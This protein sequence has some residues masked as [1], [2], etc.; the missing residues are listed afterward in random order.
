MKWLPVRLSPRHS[1]LLLALVASVAASLWAEHSA[2]DGGSAAVEAVERGQERAPERG[3]VVSAA[4]GTMPA[5]ANAADDNAPLALTRLY[6]RQ[7]V[8]TDV[9]AFRAKSWYVPPPPPPPEP[10]PKPTAPPLPFQ[11]MG[12]TEEVDGGKSVVYLTHNNE[13]HAVTVGEKFAG[14]YRLERVERAALVIRYLPLSI[15]QQLPI[16]LSE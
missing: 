3:T 1:V 6:N 10:P 13:F 9:D 5:S 7:W 14:N 8:G 4:R 16:A 11:F 15:D 12:K 2:P